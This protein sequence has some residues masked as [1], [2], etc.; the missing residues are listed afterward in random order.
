M[1]DV[2]RR[3]ELHRHEDE[4][5]I[6]GTGPVAE[7]VMFSDGSAALRWRT[8]VRSTAIYACMGDLEK[9]HGHDGKTEVVWLD[10][11]GG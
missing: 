6:S 7:G 5:G 2:P 4:T 8:A 3:F 1:A 11:I 9:I 10:P